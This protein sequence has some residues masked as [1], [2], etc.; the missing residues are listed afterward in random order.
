[1]EYPASYYKTATMKKAQ[2]KK[3]PMPE[4]LDP[5]TGRFAKGNKLSP[6][7]GRPKSTRLRISDHLTWEEKLE[8]LRTMYKLACEGNSTAINYIAPA[9]TSA[10]TLTDAVTD[11]K[12][13]D[14]VNRAGE[15]ILNEV[16]EGNLT[17]SEGSTLL[18]SVS[19][20][21]ELLIN[22]ELAAIRQRLLT[23]ETNKSQS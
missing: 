11:I 4:G 23:I 1:M 12:T 19:L 21:G 6:G 18:S 5:K 16:G 2:K 14:D 7:G 22:S 9:I 13:V 15:E 10:H 3:K 8:F 17:I 20:R